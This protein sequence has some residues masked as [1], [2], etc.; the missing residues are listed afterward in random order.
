MNG[1]TKVAFCENG[2]GYGGAII[3]LEA[4]L[5]HLPEGIESHVYTGLDAEEYRRLSRYGNWRHLKEISLIDAGWLKSRNIPF[6][7]G[8]DNLVNLA[9]LAMHYYAA[10]RRDGIE[11]VYLNNDPNC[12]LAAALAAKMR[13]I[14]MIM[15]ARGFCDDTRGT[16]WVLENIRHCIAVSHA[17]KKGIVD[18]GLPADQCTVV[19]EGLDLK[20]FHPQAAAPGLRAALGLPEDAPVITLVGGLID[21]KGQDVLLEAC[22]AIHARFPE[23]RIL[24]VGSAY[25]RDNRFAEM[26]RRQAAAPAMAGRVHLLGARSDIPALLSISSVV[27][28]T[29]TQPEP[30]GRTFLEGMA[31]GK[32]V[33]AASEGG[34]VEVIADRVDGLLIAPREPRLLAEAIIGLLADPEFSAGLASRAAAKAQ[35]YSIQAHARAIDKVIKAVIGAVPAHSPADL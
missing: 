34:P 27:L 28:H 7:S 31:M 5:D 18:I 4:F 1:I 19:H 17:V 30:F 16:R 20:L 21:W 10:F 24:L 35:L 32:P 22:P 26:I 23:A 33:I 29:S 11:L 9:P 14:P 15:H 6:A 8:I 3:S 2:A 13:G 12:N 25:G